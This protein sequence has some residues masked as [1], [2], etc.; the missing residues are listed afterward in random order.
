MRSVA[1]NLDRVRAI[2]IAADGFCFPAIRISKPL[3]VSASRDPDR[4]SILATKGMQ[5]RSGLRSTAQ[6][7]SSATLAKYRCDQVAIDR[8]NRGPDRGCDRRPSKVAMVSWSPS[9]FSP[10]SRATCCG[11]CSAISR[12]CG[13]RSRSPVSL[14]TNSRSACS[15]RRRLQ[16]PQVPRSG[17]PHLHQGFHALVISQES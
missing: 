6:L 3:V 12:A 11:G 5:V 7:R 16:Q 2:V 13:G 8:G 14:G 15:G 17:K 1:I 10:A 4:K 9:W